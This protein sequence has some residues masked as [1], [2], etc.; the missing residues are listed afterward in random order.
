MSASQHFDGRTLSYGLL[1]SVSA[2]PA[3]HSLEVVLTLSRGV[4]EAMLAWGDI[5]L[6][7]HGKRRGAAW[8]AD[9]T[10]QRLGYCTQN[11]AYY[12]H[13][14]PKSFGS[15]EEAIVA[16]AEDAN[17]TGLPFKW[18]LADSWWYRQAPP[19]KGVP[20]GG[21]V[22]WE[23][24]RAVFPHGL[25]AVLARTGWQVQGHARYWS[26]ETVY[27]RENGGAFE[28]LTDANGFAL[29]VNEAF[30][31]AL[32]ERGRRQWGL[33]VFEQDWLNFQTERFPPLLRNA[34]L[35]RQW[36]VQMGR[37][38]RKQGISIQLCMAH[39]RHVLQSVEMPSV[40]QVRGSGDYRAGNDLWAPLGVTGLFAFA[41]GIAPSKDTFWSSRL[42]PGNKWG[43]RTQEPFSRLQA[44]VAT[45]SKGPVCPS[46]A[47]GKA[48]V[49]LLMR[50]VAADGKLLQPSRPATLI[51][52]GFVAAAGLGAPGARAFPR[53]DV[54]SATSLV[55]GLRFTV[56]LVARL[57]APGELRPSDL[58]IDHGGP[59]VA[60]ES[61]APREAVTFTAMKP[62]ALKRCG[63]TDFR[64]WNISPLHT[65]GW[66]LLGEVAT[67]W[68]AVSPARF[69][70]VDSA[71]GGM[72]VVMR[73]STRVSVSRSP[74]VAPPPHQQDASP[75]VVEVECELPGGLAALTMPGATCEPFYL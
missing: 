44:V 33:A 65:S 39:S 68:V 11:G 30:W 6:A 17:R 13:N 3:G 18:W 21:V 59:L 52:A 57:R 55:G 32:F 62:L 73:G 9:P 69:I 19:P 15:Y 45:L 7:Y 20:R 35:G 46:D 50:S 54:W 4:N 23:P 24:L 51:D 49:P 70:R 42:Q 61:A 43:D 60:V 16:V 10:L 34:T 63:K 64:L 56:L 36:M 67:K 66:A 5:L 28:F 14:L 71:P 8:E 75:R 26:A 1:G 22:E 38:A 27:S 74:L 31:E 2:V 29:P 47:I 72:R 37:A 41:L 40:T 25:E 53:G 48:N 12:Y 58:G